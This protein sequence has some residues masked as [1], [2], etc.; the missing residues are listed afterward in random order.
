MKFVIASNNKGKIREFADILHELGFDAV[1]QAQLGHNVD[2]EETGTI[3][4]ENAL[5]KARAL[6]AE[7]DGDL[8]AIA[9]DSG[10]AVDALGGQPGVYSRRFAGE[11]GDDAACIKKLLLCMKDV[12]DEKRTARFV[13]A[14]ACVFPDGS[15]TVVRGTCEGTILHEV[16]G[17]NGFGYDPLFVPVGYSQS[18]GELDAETKNVISHRYN[19]AKKFGQRV[20]EIFSNSQN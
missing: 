17:T 13:S 6:F 7:L 8:A 3:F 4:E 18:F 20:A 2:P 19:A 16:R 9:D 5:I 14:I 11:D 15:E 1:G 10:L 12:P